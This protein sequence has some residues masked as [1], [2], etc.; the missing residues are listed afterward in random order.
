M[1]TIH[2]VH[3]ASLVLMTL[4][5]LV[6][7]ISGGQAAIAQDGTSG[8][9]P[10]SSGGLQS[11]VDWLIAQ[12]TAEGGFPGFDG[13]S[14][15][16]ITVDALISLAA[17][18]QSGVDLETSIDDAL[19]YLSSGDLALVY[20]QTGVGQAAKLVLALIATGQNIDDFAGVSPLLI[21]E[22]GQDPETGIYGASLYDHALAILAIDAADGEV[23]VSAVDAIEAAQS[24]NGGWGF[25]G[26]TDPVAA[27]GNTTSIIIQ[28]LVAIDASVDQLIADGLSYLETTVNEDGAAAFN[29]APE[30]VPDANS[31]ALVA[32]ALI[33]TDGNPDLQLAA[34]AGFQN[35]SGAFFFTGEDTSDNLFS[36]IQAIVPLAGA[37]LPIV[38]VS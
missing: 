30:S 18:R 5:A 34:L 25:D 9:T 22:N 28:A 7:A 16:G 1:R 27:D 12:Q 3:H 24:G 37:V 8:A 29:D 36:T 21:V 17:A 26:S 14:D 10:P 38:P 32:Q 2:R 15:P 19:S 13:A 20:T 33:A 6:C 23:P 31:T 35:A 4:I 11:S